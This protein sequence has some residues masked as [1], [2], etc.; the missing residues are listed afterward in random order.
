MTQ[1]LKDIHSDSIAVNKWTTHEELT[2]KW[3]ELLSN[4]PSLIDLS[5]TLIQDS[6]H[7]HH[8]RYVGH[9]VSAVAP[10]VS[11]IDMM[12]S[13][14]NNGMGVYEMGAAGTIIENAVVEKFCE[15]FGF[16]DGSGFFTSGGTLANL[17]VMLAARQAKGKIDVWTEG[18][19][20]PMG[21]LVSDQA[22]YC[23][24]RAARIMGWG[25]KGVIKI[26]V[27]EQFR[28]RTELIPDYVKQAKSD[29]IELV[30]IVGNAPSTSCLLYTSPSPRDATLSRMP[31]SA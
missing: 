21:L 15:A 24:D 2:K 22:H 5:K 6:M 27:D 4:N 14:L 9:Q 7:I 10:Q 18:S 30:A 12:I 19:Q 17:T 23:V 13:L 16:P 31:S 20:R 25:S 11:V 1:Y 8:P 3:K 26:P 28:M 29:G